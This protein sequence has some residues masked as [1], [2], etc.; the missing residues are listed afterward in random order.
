MTRRAVSQDNALAEILTRVPLTVPALPSIGAAQPRPGVL[1]AMSP[2]TDKIQIYCVV[3][4]VESRSLRRAGLVTFWS[5]GKLVSGP[6]K[7]NMEEFYALHAKHG[8]KGFWVE[9]VRWRS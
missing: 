3:G 8:S 5:H 7:L 9:G 6:K 4:T 2:V 1:V